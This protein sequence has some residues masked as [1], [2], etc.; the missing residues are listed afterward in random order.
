[1]KDVIVQAL[2]KNRKDSESDRKS[3]E[4]YVLVEE[5]D[6]LDSSRKANKSN[7]MKRIIDPSENVYLIQLSWKGAGRF[8]LED[9][10]KL[11]NEHGTLTETYSEPLG[12]K[13]GLSPSLRRQS[14]IIASGVRRLS[15]SFYG[16]SGENLGHSHRRTGSFAELSGGNGNHGSLRQLPTGQHSQATPHP[17]AGRDN[18]SHHM[19]RK[20]VPLPKF[21]QTQSDS[22]LQAMEEQESD[23][24]TLK[25]SSGSGINSSEVQATNSSSNSSTTLNSSNSATGQASTTS[26]PISKKL[27]RITLRKLKIW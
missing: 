26:I 15:R 11:A 10:D 7:K 6:V 22:D 27:S 17:L 16:G 25:N 23:S 12:A 18:S 14:R 24:V 20:R 1:V 4:D 9:K 21:G 5:I 8:I 19:S 3:P 13:A 2:A